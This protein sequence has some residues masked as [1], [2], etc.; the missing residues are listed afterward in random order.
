M[1]GGRDV[2]WHCQRVAHGIRCE[3]TYN[4]VEL[5]VMNPSGR[6]RRD[7]SPRSSAD[8]SGRQPSLFVPFQQWPILPSD[9]F[10][11]RIRDG[12]VEWVDVKRGA[13][14]GNL[15]EVFGQ[16]RRESR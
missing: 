7:V 16:L 2:Y 15:V 14:M 12:E 4:A 8:A 3:D 9:T 11:I 6:C 1:G 13:V 5:D 10:V